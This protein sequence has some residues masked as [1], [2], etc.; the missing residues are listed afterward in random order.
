VY[1]PKG[2][3]FVQLA[4]YLGKD[5]IIVN[6]P[7]TGGLA[8]RHLRH[9]KIRVKHI[10]VVRDGR[11][12]CR[13]Y[14]Q[15][16][17]GTEFRWTVK[18]WFL[19]AAESFRFDEGDSGVLHVRYEDVVRDQ[20]SAIEKFGAF[21]G[22]TYPDNFYRFWE[23]EHHMAA[24]NAHLC[25]MIRRFQ[26]DKAFSGRRQQ[27]YENEYHRLHRE[28]EKPLFD[29]KWRTELSRQDLLLFDSF[30]GSANESWG[31]TRD[32]FAADEYRQLSPDL[33]N[34]TLPAHSASEQ[35]Q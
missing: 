4:A 9:R 34:D 16:N 32:V 14:V 12:I 26:Q 22:L 23:F 6:N 7:I 19:P 29:E 13:S 5:H 25:G 10:R 15:N 30:A 20:F 1:N 8:D 28:P 31:Y 21:L 33:E 27:F 35:D 3:F 17:P 11:A 2:N 24:G 18:K